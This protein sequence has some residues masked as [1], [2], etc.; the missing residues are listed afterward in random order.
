MVSA[1]VVLATTARPG[2]VLIRDLVFVP[3][4]AIDLRL[5]GISG[6]L[7]RGVPSDLVAALISRVFGAAVTERL[8]LLAVVCAAGLGAAR[9]YGRVTSGGRVGAVAAC[10]AAIWNPF[11]AERLLIG[12]WVVLVG[13]A[14]L[15]W[16]VLTALDWARRT[17][18][19][20]PLA[21]LV[22]ALAGSLGGP[23]AWVLWAP[24]AIL[25]LILDA[26]P[27]PRAAQVASGVGVAVLAAVP[28]L[29]PAL[30]LPGGTGSSRAGFDAFAINADTPFGSVFSALTGGGIWNAATV[31]PGRDSVIGA[32]AAAAVLVLAVVGLASA[33]IPTTVRGLSVASV[34]GLLIA[35]SS[36]S[37][38]GRTVLA[39]LPGGSLVRDSARAL[40]PWV[41]LAAV[42]VGA[43][44]DRVY[45]PA[46]LA[47][48]VSTALVCL[49]AVA[50]LPG[51]AFGVS[52]SLRPVRLPSDYGA[53]VQ[54][55]SAD[56]RPGSVV[57]LPWAPYRVPAWNR[58]R[59]TAEPLGR[60]LARPVISDHDL[61]V[62]IDGRVV[63]VPGEDHAAQE[64][65]RVVARGPAPSGPAAVAAGL[66]A[67]GVGWVVV[68]SPDPGVDL[69]ALQQVYGGR[70]LRVY[71][72]PGAAAGSHRDVAR[73]HVPNRR[74]VVTFDLVAAGTWVLMMVL[75]ARNERRHR[76]PEVG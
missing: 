33:R 3:E 20:P 23:P 9:L 28:W 30:L 27:R 45:R 75:S 56:P 38:I 54:R 66:A 1:A 72:V 68:D 48:K 7:P 15:P 10:L 69:S 53:V 24:A 14:A 2:L 8:V 64:V 42:G 61:D 74:T 26:P 58:D 29:V 22:T 4:P 40:A 76:A 55:L 11:V 34:L 63:R 39:A 35:V 43:T 41:V 59:P 57:V 16:A 62:V 60:M 32:L 6:A 17:T 73:E 47:A 65:A 51:L 13:Y 5:L 67:L 37:H 31:P 71:A 44:C 50:A 25:T 52:G 46:D 19:V 36:S 70:F 21:F 18:A 12:Q 49:A